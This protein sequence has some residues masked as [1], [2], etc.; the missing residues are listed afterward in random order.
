MAVTVHSNIADDLRRRLR[1][2]EVLTSLFDRGRYATDA[3]HYQVMP[4]AVVVPRTTDAALKSI[5]EQT[6]APR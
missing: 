3:S 1:D 5:L 2:A 4:A 6:E